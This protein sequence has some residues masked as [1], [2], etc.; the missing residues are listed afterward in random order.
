MSRNAFSAYLFHTP[1]LIAVT[2]ALHKFSAPPLVQFLV[3][4]SIAVPITFFTSEY[5]FRQ[6]PLLKRVFVIS[7]DVE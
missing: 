1:L 4:G 7:R 2:L 3:A 5:V 6:V